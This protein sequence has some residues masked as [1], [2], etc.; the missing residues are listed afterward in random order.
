MANK[1]AEVTMIRIDFYRVQLI[2]EKSGL[3]H[4]ESKIIKSPACAINYVREACSPDTYPE[5]HFG[6]LTLSTKNDVLGVHEI[7][8]GSLNTSIVHP[9]EVFKPA[10]LNNAASIITFHNHPSGNPEP[11]NEDREAFTRLNEAAKILGMKCA[12]HIIIG[13]DARYW[14]AA[15]HG[16]AN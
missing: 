1:K 7:S 14:S 11:S 16:L 9:R 2:K 6:I 3:Y 13:H 4:V 10:I 12:D 15:E 8:V 5:E